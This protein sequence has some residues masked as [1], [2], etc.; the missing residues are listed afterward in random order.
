MKSAP[1]TKTIKTKIINTKAD[2]S[3]IQSRLYNSLS[4]SKSKS[5]YQDESQIK[6]I[7]HSL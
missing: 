7:R 4:K 2:Y 3:H 1:P 6:I 5:K